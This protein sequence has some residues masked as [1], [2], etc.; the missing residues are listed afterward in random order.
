MEGLRFEIRLLDDKQI[1]GYV[2]ENN[3]NQVVELILS[4]LADGSQ[5]LIGFICR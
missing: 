3:K 5:L 2:H 4:W 1:M